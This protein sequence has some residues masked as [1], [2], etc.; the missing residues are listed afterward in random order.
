MYTLP[1]VHPDLHVLLGVAAAAEEDPPHG[2]HVEEVEAALLA[3]PLV[4]GAVDCVELRP[5]VTQQRLKP[6]SV[7]RH[8][9]A[10]V[11]V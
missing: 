1:A 10:T 6:K 9:V 4:L 3:A 7:E 11:D 8:V 2:G 5:V